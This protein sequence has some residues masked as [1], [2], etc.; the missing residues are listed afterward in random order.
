MYILMSLA[1]P[2]VLNLQ[3]RLWLTVRE[4]LTIRNNNDVQKDAIDSCAFQEEEIKL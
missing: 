2:G 1:F 4:F 3:N